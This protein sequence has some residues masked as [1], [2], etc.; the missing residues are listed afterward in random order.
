VFG[1]FVIGAS[2]IDTMPYMPARFAAGRAR[3]SGL[4]VRW[5]HAGVQLRGEWLDGQPFEGP[6]T[7][8]G[9]ID[10]IVHVPAMGPVTALAR[11]ERLDYDTAPPRA[12]FTHRY[13]GGARIRIW[14]SLAASIGVGHQGGQMT[15]TKRTAVDA[16][17]GLVLRMAA[18][19]P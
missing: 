15:Q 4:D 10:A 13:W 2:Y 16:G 17:I 14:R 8:G 3:F 5:M 11:A 19:R 6:T 18:Q 9:Y 1:A 7:A 12:L